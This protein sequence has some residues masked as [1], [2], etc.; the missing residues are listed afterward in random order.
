MD[1]P[2]NADIVLL[3]AHNLQFTT[4]PVYDVWASCA[5]SET[6]TDLQILSSNLHK[7]AFGRRDLPRWGSYSAPSALQ[8][9][10]EGR[11]GRERKGLRIVGKGGRGK[12]RT[13]RGREGKEGSVR[14][15]REQKNE[16][17]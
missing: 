1:L 7:N 13:L 8:T 3:P 2:N 5:C 4:I 14:G 6:L 15:G 11:E 12:G 16:G 9:P 17:G 10:G